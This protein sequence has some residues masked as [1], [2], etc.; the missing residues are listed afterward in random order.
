MTFRYTVS[1]TFDDDAV[2]RE[3]LE[4]LARGHCADVRAGGAL[5]AEVIALD[6]DDITFEVRYDFPTREAF[7]QYEADH[8]P[9]LRDEGLERFPT[10]RGISYARSSG[11]LVHSEG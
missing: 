9:G 4:W 1:A 3:W 5:N 11:E 10:H 6:G 7:E 8:A 2:A